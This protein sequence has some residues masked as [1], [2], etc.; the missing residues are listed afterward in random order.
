[1]GAPTP[2]PYSPDGVPSDYH[3]FS[4]MGQVLAEQPFKTFKDVLK[5]LDTWILMKVEVFF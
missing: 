2:L 1:M 3:L 4:S 5:L